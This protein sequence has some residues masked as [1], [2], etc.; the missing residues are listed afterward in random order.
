M[1]GAKV[2]LVGNISQGNMSQVAGERH[3]SLAGQSCP[4]YAAT[5]APGGIAH[6]FVEDVAFFC[7]QGGP[8]HL[9]LLKNKVATFAK[10]EKEEDMI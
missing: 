5:V 10:V 4:N 2:V 6:L 3:G 7:L 1:I 9:Y 8:G